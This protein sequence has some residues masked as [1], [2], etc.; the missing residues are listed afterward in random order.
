MARITQR[1]LVIR[2]SSIGDIVHALP[3]VSALGESLPEAE[4]TWV[5]ENRYATLLEDNPF[6]HRIVTLDTLRWRRQ[7]WS[8]GTL[9]EI[10]NSLHALRERE[11][12]AI[13]DFQGLV[14]T[15]V[16][17]WLCR[18]KKRVGFERPWLKEREAS[19]FYSHRVSARGR[20]HAIEE[21]L[22]LVEPLGASCKAWHFPLPDSLEARRSV[23]KLIRESG[24]GSFILASPGA[25]W[26]AKR[27]PPASY[28]KL[29]W[30]LVRELDESVILTGAPAEEQEITEIV[31]QASS[32]RIRYLPTNLREFIALTRKARLF[33]GGD[34]GPL[35][36]AAG[37]GIPIVAFYGPTDPA[38][39][40][41]FSPDDVVLS[42]HE[43]VNHTR[44]AKRPRY[45][46]G[47]GVDDAF[48]AV[49]ERLRRKA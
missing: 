35:H 9:R 1:F 10:K 25:G 29:A 46:E 49:S 7:L 47:I 34:T 37:L 20:I 28:A 21:D 8:P 41:P 17:A 12:D 22:A 36:L 42:T 26:P 32:P 43:P 39:N 19:I 33:I 48:R 24:I 30:R 38:R 40:G 11:F 16:L 13:I 5:A 14:K 18:S 3:A 31:R 4:I 44:R 2:L 27:W 6:I 45:L 15:G 23:E